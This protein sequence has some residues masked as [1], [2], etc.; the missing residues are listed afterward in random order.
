MY[1][2]P[3]SELEKSSSD[4]GVSRV[5]N[6]LLYINILSTF[7]YWLIPYVDFIF[8]SEVEIE[9]Y[10]FNGENALWVYPEWLYQTTY[11]MY[12]ISYVALRMRIKIFKWF[13]LLLSLFGTLCSLFWG[14]TVFAAYELTIMYFMYYIDGAIL[15]LLFFSSVSRE[16]N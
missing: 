14:V 9:A 11:I 3:T 13:F 10:E 7:V 16:F 15:A 1:D 2:T 12:F 5:F 8:L 6:L 4:H